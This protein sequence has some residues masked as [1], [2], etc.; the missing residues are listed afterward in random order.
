MTFVG[1]YPVRQC[2]ARAGPRRSSKAGALRARL[3]HLVFQQGG[4]V[5]LRHS[6]LQLTDHRPERLSA[7]T[8][9]ATH[10]LQ[11]ALVLDDAHCPSTTPSVGT[12]V[13]DANAARN[14]LRLDK[15]N[16]RSFSNPRSMRMARDKQVRDRPAEESKVTR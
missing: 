10:H 15:R 6:G 12:M 11:L 5:V 14:L 4:R 3:A 9:R 13:T 1:R 2:P 8:T 7:T 16:T